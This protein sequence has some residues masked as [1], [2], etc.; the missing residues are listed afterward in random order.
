MFNFKDELPGGGP[1]RSYAK[2]IEY[3]GSPKIIAVLTQMSP[4][5]FSCP[6]ATVY[7]LTFTFRTKQKYRNKYRI[8]V[9][10]WILFISIGPLTAGLSTKRSSNTWGA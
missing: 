3:T 5:W 6:F 9:F 2:G 10:L 7:V 4:V 1:N 8:K